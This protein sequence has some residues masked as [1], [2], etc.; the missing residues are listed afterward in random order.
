MAC[1]IVQCSC[2]S[3]CINLPISS[4]YSKYAPKSNFKLTP[5]KCQT[6][7]WNL[8]EREAISTKYERGERFQVV[9]KMVMMRDVDGGDDGVDD[10]KYNN[11]GDEDPPSM[12]EVK[13]FR[14]C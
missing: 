4:K 14:W 8:K 3:L 13:D 10:Y 12:R 11:D 7:V 1:A 2:I 9:L 6:H 5:T